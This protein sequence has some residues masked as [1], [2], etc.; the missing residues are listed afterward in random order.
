MKIQQNNCS[1]NF[2]AG[3][4]KQIRAEIRSCDINKISKELARNNIQSDFKGNKI[5]AWC[6]LK[7]YELFK[8][9]KLTLP[10][11]IFVENFQEN[12]NIMYPDSIGFNNA[13]PCKI[14]KNKNFIVPEKTLFFNENLPD[15]EFDNVWNYLDEIA[16]KQYAEKAVP[17]DF[18]LDTFLHEFAHVAH[19]GN[20]IKRFN[21]S[22]LEY[23]YARS[24][25][26]GFLEKFKM[27][28]YNIL[29]NICEYA[30]ESPHEAIAC[31]MAN[32][33][34]NNIDKNTLKLKHNFILNSPYKKLSLKEHLFGLQNQN[35]LDDLIRNFWYGKI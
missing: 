34:V 20:L 19:E 14:Y 29:S 10:N 32:R 30:A 26:E 4:T 6:C 28:Y 33:F 18:F 11:G 2:H 24:Q 3:L 21:P 23:H 17:N 7:C 25:D 8:S 35:N 5:V 12:L 27:K 13:L 22:K 16:N 31:D 15:N 9:L 1:P